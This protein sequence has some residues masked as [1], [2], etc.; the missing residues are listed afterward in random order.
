V[1]LSHPHRPPRTCRPRGAD[2]RCHGRG[3]ADLA[4]H[5]SGPTRPCTPALQ[6]RPG[7]SAGRWAFARQHRLVVARRPRRSTGA[8]R[9]P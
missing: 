3:G 6:L 4:A 5:A 9:W 1:F 7:R 8:W 2:R